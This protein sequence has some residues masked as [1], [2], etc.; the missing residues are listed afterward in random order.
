MTAT[1]TN[2]AVSIGGTGRLGW[3]DGVDIGFTKGRASGEVESRR[4]LQAKILKKLCK[5]CIMDRVCATSN[6]A[7]WEL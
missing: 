5:E 1:P 7:S 6:I 3:F 2:A 4:A